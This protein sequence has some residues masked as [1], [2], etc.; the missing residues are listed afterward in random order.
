MK[1]YLVYKPFM[2]FFRRKRMA[3]F[4]DVFRPGPETTILDIGGTK[5]NWNLISS[6]SQIVLLNLSPPAPHDLASYPENYT[7]CQGDGTNL[8]FEDGSFDIVFSNSVIE[9]LRSW[10][11]Q[12]KFAEH[13]RR[14]GKKV[15]VQTPA[16]HFFLEPHLFTP[17]VHYLP[18]TWQRRLL[19]NFTVW[20]LFTRPTSEQVEAFL[21]EVRLLDRAE[22]E[23]LFPDCEIAE[24]KFLFFIKGFV[25]FRN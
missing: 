8:Q 9:H 16:R 15:W 4:V 17:F 5:F 24:E 13:V 7:F 2:R 14:V 22:M 21:E 10:E 20:G 1:F 19:R 23:Q 12:R 11:N 25:A 3:Q 18:K 6:K